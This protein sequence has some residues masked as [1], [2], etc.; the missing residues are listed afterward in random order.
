DHEP[1]V[2]VDRLAGTEHGL[3][4]AGL[5]VLR[6]AGGVGAGRKAG[7]DEDGVVAGGIEPAPGLVGH[8]AAAQLAA[9]LE[10]EGRGQVD[11]ARGRRDELR[12]SASVAMRRVAR[13]SAATAS[14]TGV[15]SRSPAAAAASPL[16]EMRASNRTRLCCERAWA[17]IS[18]SASV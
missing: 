12:H 5:G 1:A 15:A 2:G 18:P 8:A 14:S 7:E 3:P 17:G 9:A 6:M 10:G 13:A 16:R 4:P 11:V